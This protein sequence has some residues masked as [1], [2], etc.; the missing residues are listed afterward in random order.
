MGLLIKRYRI[1]RVSIARYVLQE[2]SI[3]FP[4]WVQVDLTKYHSKD[5]ITETSAFKIKK[6]NDG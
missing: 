5:E 4:F 6:I 2:W 3:W 1:A